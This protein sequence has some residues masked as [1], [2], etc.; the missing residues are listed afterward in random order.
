MKLSPAWCRLDNSSSWLLCAK[1]QVLFFHSDHE[2]HWRNTN[3]GNGY[4]ENFY[5]VQTVGPVVI[6]FQNS[7]EIEASFSMFGHFPGRK[8]S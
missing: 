5:V 7:S 1:C 8:I 3:G 4:C 6:F 2:L